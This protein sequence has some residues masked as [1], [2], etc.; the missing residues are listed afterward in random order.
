MP[1]YE[2]TCSACGE[3]HE[4]LQKISEP[5][6]VDCPACGKPAL[7]RR[8]SAAGFRLAGSGWY[9]TDFKK[10]GRRNLSG[11]SGEKSGGKSGDAS[12]G[13]SDAKG[14]SQKKSS[15]EGGNSAGKSS[16]RPDS[17]PAKPSAGGDK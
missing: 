11:D 7:K 12:S 2:Y 3:D 13:K 8:V 9:E 4:Q 15:G 6:L 10:D 16:S 1:I 14:E 17:K 5:D